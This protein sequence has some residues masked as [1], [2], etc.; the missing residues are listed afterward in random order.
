MD[1]FGPLVYTLPLDFF[2]TSALKA[3]GD[4][5]YFFEYFCFV[6]E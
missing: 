1:V 2:G 4:Y 3:T 5:W 6:K